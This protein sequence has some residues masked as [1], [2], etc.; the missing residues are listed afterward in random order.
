MAKKNGKGDGSY[1]SPKKIM[2]LDTNILINDPGSFRQFKEHDVVIPLTVIEELDVLKVHEASV[3]ESARKAIRLL[4][5]LFFE[6]EGTSYAQAVSLGNGKGSISVEDLPYNSEVKKRRGP[7]TND[8]M[9]IS[10]AFT[11]STK[12]SGKN[13]V[14]F[15]SNDA[16]LRIK[17]AK[18]NLVV[19]GYKHDNV[20][21]VEE[22]FGEIKKIDVS[23]WELDFNKLFAKGSVVVKKQYENELVPNAPYILNTNNNQSALVRVKKDAKAT[24]FERVEKEPIYGKIGPKNAEQTFAVSMMNDSAVDLVAFTGIAG[25]GKTLVAI[26]AALSQVYD[27]DQILIARPIVAMSD[28]DLGFLPGD[29]QEKVSPY[30][31]P[32]FDNI[33]V[34]KNTNGQKKGDKIDD[35]ISE[36]KLLIEP[37]AYIRGRTFNNVILIVDEAQN[38]TPNE[39]KTI[40]TRMGVNSKLVFTGDVNQIDH[41]YLDSRSNGLTYLIDKMPGYVNAGHI[42]FKKGVRS[43]ISEWAA[44]SL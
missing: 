7:Q 33:K 22:L 39:I 40:V 9:I 1:S 18:L 16:A 42:D 32:L 3:G 36:G 34:L 41:P 21:N 31:R 44:E 35:F 26:G 43:L 2:V 20:K 5:A 38:L 27:Y 30:M 28:K 4:D 25:S 13:E 6:K 24:M 15:V 37:L 11:L 17:A 29:V 19:Q 14:V 23:S 10:V 8:N 12:Y